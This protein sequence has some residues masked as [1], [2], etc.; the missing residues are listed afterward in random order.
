[1]DIALLTVKD[2]RL[3]VLLVRRANEPEKG[4]WALPGG[5]LDPAVDCS[6]DDT[7]RRVLRSKTHVDIRYTEQV[8]VFSGQ[9]RDPRGW[10]L[11]VVY[12]ALLPGDKVSAVAGDKAE[13]I[14]WMDAMELN[15]Q[16]AFDHT[17]LLE[18]AVAKLRDKVE[19]EALPLHLLPGRFT[20]TE[21]QRTCEVVL[22]R[23]LDKSAFRRRIKEEPALVEI[24]GEFLRG[25]Q[26][27]AQL[28][29]TAEDFQF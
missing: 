12:Y 2:E 27:P 11:S 16:L 7:V 14:E 5:V 8:Q 28:Y 4:R 25:P 29:T 9:D 24:E 22:G 23:P 26:R 3:H 18:A 6:L 10:S 20:L 1:M 17:L 21:L 13:A 19:R 15:R